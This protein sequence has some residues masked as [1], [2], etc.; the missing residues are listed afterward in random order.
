[1]DFENSEWEKLVILELSREYDYICRFRRIH[2]RPAGIALFDSDTLWGKFDSVTRTI[3]VSRKLVR[4]HSWQNVM[5]VFLHEMAHQLVNEENFQTAFHEKPHGERFQ[6]AC[7]RLGV[8]DQYRRAGLDMQTISLD[9]KSEPRN[10]KTE[11]ILTLAQKLLSLATST[12][13]HEAALAMARVRELYAKNNLDQLNE[14]AKKRYVQLVISTG[15]KRLAAWEQ[16][17]ISLLMEHFFVKIILLKQFDAK[18]MSHYQALELIGTRENVLMAEF[19]YYFLR[20]QVE[21]LL[22]RALALDANGWNRSMDRS[23]RNSFRLGVLEG[24]DKKLAMAEKF[25]RNPSSAVKTEIKSTELT[26]ES[27]TKL[28][29]ELTLVGQALEKFHKDT[30]LDDY[31]AEIYLRLGRKEESSVKISREAF[32]AGHIAG[33]TITLQKPISESR[34]NHQRAILG[35]QL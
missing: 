21:F 12:N 4:E 1:M 5:G 11:K 18:K 20:Q 26:A 35:R 8:P 13:E 32:A 15:K 22:T 28:A 27:K 31:V 24:F 17:M 25:E 19:V 14:L 2:L 30:R 10:E 6:A 23:D 7:K 33:Q 29:T 16:R 34:A 9:W 3:F